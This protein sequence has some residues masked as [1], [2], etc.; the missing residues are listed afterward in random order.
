MYTFSQLI[1]TTTNHMGCGNSF[2]FYGVIMIGKKNRLMHLH[3]EMDMMGIYA[4]V[5]K[6]LDS[7]F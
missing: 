6:Q 5:V 4:F 1:K 7:K 3:S 2:A